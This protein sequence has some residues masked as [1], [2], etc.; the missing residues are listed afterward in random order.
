[1]S[2][3][4][5]APVVKFQ[6]LGMRLADLGQVRSSRECMVAVDDFLLHNVVNGKQCMMLSVAMVVEA[7]AISR[8]SKS[9]PFVFLYFPTSL[10]MLCSIILVE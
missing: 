2:V 6:R 1:M 4:G 8:S 9:L 7:S 3:V 10:P 5:G